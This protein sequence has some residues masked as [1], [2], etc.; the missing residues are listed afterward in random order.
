MSFHNNFNSNRLSNSLFE[1]NTLEGNKHESSTNSEFSLTS[2]PS[3]KRKLSFYK[4]FLWHCSFL[5]KLKNEM[6]PNLP[7]IKLHNSGIKLH[8]FA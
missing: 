3:K 4:T 7:V 2:L 8:T 6:S 5:A 1:R